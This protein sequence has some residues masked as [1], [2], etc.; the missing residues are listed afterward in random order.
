[1]VDTCPRCG[2]I[3]LDKGEIF[4]FTSTPTYLKY[5]LQEAI[6]KK[7]G[8]GRLCPKTGEPMDNILLFDSISVEY[9]PKAGGLWFDKDELEKL[10]GVDP[11][12]LSLK[13]DSMSEE[14]PQP[15]DATERNLAMLALRRRSANLAD[16]IL[17]SVFTVTGLYALL[18][19]ALIIASLHFNL[20]PGAALILG[21]IAALFQFFLGPFMMD[22]TLGWLYSFRWAQRTDI[23]PHLDAFIERVCREKKMS[24]PHVGIIEDGSPQAFTYGHTPDNARL[25][26][27]RGLIDLLQPNELEAV[28]AHELGHAKHWD[29]LVMTMAGLVPLILY[30][31][32]RTLIRSKGRGKGKGYTLA[33]AIVSYALYIVSE[34]IV[35][36]FSRIR[37]YFADR[38]AGE[39]TRDPNALSSALVKI[40]YGLAGK[41]PAQKETGDDEKPAPERAAGMEAIR[42]MGIFDY[43]T[44]SALAI[45]AYNPSLGGE[46]DKEKLK[47][48]MFWD[49]WNPW[50]KFYELNSTHPLIAERLEALTAQAVSLNQEPYIIFDKRKPESYWD[51]FFVDL[52]V[53]WLPLALLIIPCFIMAPALGRDPQSFFGVAALCFGAGLL[54]NTVFAYSGSTDREMTIAGLLKKIKVSGIRPVGCA[55]KGKIVGKGVPGLI[56]SEDFVLRDETGIIFLDYN[57]PLPLWN[58]LFGLLKAES[59]QGEDVTVTGWY[60]RSPV[61]YIEIRTITDSAGKTRRC[62]TYPGKLT[63][64]LGLIAVGLALLVWTALKG[65]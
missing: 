23:P 18:T 30:Y 3:W 33:V 31:I 28:A 8:S 22:W 27:S 56:F 64:A 39:V 25:V 15:Q 57:Q 1:M 20:K 6:E 41:E 58:L 54:V 47:S 35:L 14:E 60:R 9:S 32:Y 55:V 63:L 46:V 5:K 21:A 29:M 19:L 52:L 7:T 44:A 38:F 16:L 43:R 10:P 62:F 65:L 49:K 48:A 34:Y 17:P 26:V 59:L 61:P 2:G 24:Y 50:A 37:E 4:H 42:P 40:G 36:W 11:R 51:E 45:T 53:M 13:L 12:R